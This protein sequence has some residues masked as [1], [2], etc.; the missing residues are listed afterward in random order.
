MEG[1]VTVAVVVVVV[2]VVVDVNVK[3]VVI[4]GVVA[5]VEMTGGGLILTDLS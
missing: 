4:A 2:V 1:V 5:D 3:V